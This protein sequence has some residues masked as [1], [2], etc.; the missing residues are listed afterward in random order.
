MNCILTQNLVTAKYQSDNSTEH[1]HSEIGESKVSKQAAANSSK[2][3]L[4]NKARRKGTPIRG[5][6]SCKKTAS[7]NIASKRWG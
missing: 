2:S 1:M 7:V 6:G 3:K 5:K 4:R